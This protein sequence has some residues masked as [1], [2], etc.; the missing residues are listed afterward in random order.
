MKR[1]TKKKSDD[2]IVGLFPPM[3]SIAAFLAATLSMILSIALLNL[4]IFDFYF[5]I[6]IEHVLMYLF[7]TTIIFS[8]VNFAVVRGSFFAVKVLQ[9]YFCILFIIFLP[10]VFLIV[11]K[12]TF[13][14][15][16]L[17]AVVFLLMSLYLLQSKYYQSFVEYQFD[18][19]EDI[20]EVRAEIAAERAKHGNKF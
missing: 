6:K 13:I 2:D 9:W 5:E 11:E 3:K 8:G 18:A 14:Y 16:Y 15:A 7:T 1:Q 19:L 4:L 20:K 12:V 10:T 17:L